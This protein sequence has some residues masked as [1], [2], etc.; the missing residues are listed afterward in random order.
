MPCC[1]GYCAAQE[2]FNRKVA[3]RDLKR[4]RRRGADVTTRLLLEELR[5]RPLEGL[6]ILDVG[7]GIGVIGLELVH[8]NLASLTMVDASPA[9]LE[10]ARNALGS[11]FGERPVEF[12]L[13]DFA[14]I[15]DTI[16]D[17]D[18]VTLD[19]V[20]CCYPEVETLLGGAVTKARQLLAFTY[21]R[22]RW[23][24]RIV[25]ALENSMR[26]LK[27][28]KFRVFIHSPERMGALLEAAKFGLVARR[29]TLTWVLDIYC[30]PDAI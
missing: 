7:G 10:V 9:Y 5:S 14:V 4:Y 21:P 1:S 27:R 11:Q 2:Q 15:A 26:W 13:G 28:S 12:I 18:V 29:E 25:V 6:R 30:R 8:A 17:A 22:D 20:V 3:N 23:Y 19:R 16:P 24:V